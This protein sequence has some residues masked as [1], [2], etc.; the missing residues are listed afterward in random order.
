[1]QQDRHIGR[2]KHITGSSSNRMLTIEFDADPPAAFRGELGQAINAFHGLTVPFQASRFGFRLLD[3]AQRMVG[4]LSCV[5]SWGWMFVDA[6]WVD[7]GHR[8]TGG[9]RMLM[10]A[11]ETHAVA[12]GCHSVWLDT[13]QARGFYE[14]LG[15]EVFGQ[16]EDYPGP[17]TRWFLRKHVAADANQSDAARHSANDAGPSMQGPTP[18]TSATDDGAPGPE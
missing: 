14:R 9:G 17:Q 2:N 7:A 5:E 11:A 8:G 1:V 3:K 12:I 4:G 6:V 13:F 18:V 15:Y 10:R 16:L